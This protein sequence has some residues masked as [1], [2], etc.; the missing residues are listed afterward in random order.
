MRPI[1]Y[2]IFIK[3][4]N[5]FKYF[6]E[7]SP[8]EIW[9]D[10]SGFFINKYYFIQNGFSNIKFWFKI[11]WN[12]RDFDWYYTFIILQAKIK[13]Q[14]LRFEELKKCRY[15]SVNI[16]KDIKN[17]KK[18]EYLIQ[19]IIDDDYLNSAEFERLEKIK[20]KLAREHAEYM[21]KQDMKLLFKIL[22][23]EIKKWWD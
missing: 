21:E 22:E 3:T 5:F 9:D 12:D 17:M 4:K 8:E 13:K 19:R 7:N 10:F 15:H 20:Y 11:I 14:R 18:C 23:E 2:F 16:D 1:L 6:I